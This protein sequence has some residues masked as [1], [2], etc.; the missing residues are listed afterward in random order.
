MR[1]PECKKL[2]K[3]VEDGSV[4]QISLDQ[5]VELLKFANKRYCDGK[6]V[7]TDDMFDLIK[8]H[9]ENKDPQNPF[10]ATVGA[11]VGVCDRR[12]T[13]LPYFMGSMN[14]IKSDGK[15]LAKFITNYSGSYIITDKLDGNSALL[16]YNPDGKVKMF[17]RGDGEEGQ[18]ISEIIP[19]IQ[20]VPKKLK[21]VKSEF[22][23][24]GELII[25]KAD[26]ESM[27]SGRANAR[28]MVAGLI[29]A[30]KL[31][32]KYLPTVHFVAYSQVFPTMQTPVTQLANLKKHGFE[33]V[34]NTKLEQADL[35]F[36]R[37]SEILVSRKQTSPYEVDGIVIAHN[38]AHPLVTKKERNPV[39]SFA[40]K[41]AIMEDSA[42]VIV[43]GVEWNI[44]SHGYLKP[45]VLFDPVTLK[46]VSI[47]RATG[48]HGQFIQSNRIGVGAR[49]LLTRS[50][51]V[52]PHI[53]K[54][55]APAEKT[56]MP[57]QPYEWTQGGKDIKIVITDQGNAEFDAKQVE[58]FFTTLKVKGFGPGYIKKVIDAGFD[59][60]G[61]ILQMTTEQFKTVPG[62]DKKA[63][64]FHDTIKATVKSANCVTIM[65]A[66][67]M[68]GRGM[69]E[70]KMQKI[71]ETVPK[72][73]DGN[74]LPTIAEMEAAGI[75]DA[76]TIQ[77]FLQGLPKFKAFMRENGIKACDVTVAAAKPVAEPTGSALDNQ[78]VLM[79]GF[80]NDDLAKQVVANGGRVVAAFSKKV[81]ILVAKETDKDTGKM[82]EA[83]AAGIRIMSVDQFVKEYKL[84]K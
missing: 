52:I 24:R 41:N 30:K 23:V 57:T 68:F 53:V 83:R 9:L 50:G 26:F 62:I 3:Q 22:T 4:D 71:M 29:N 73:F 21:G 31:D 10:L 66:T 82:K 39:H 14:K 81:T 64:E 8:E 13:K 67:N 78:V 45:T 59:T 38:H 34:Y 15:E 35:T 51:D 54:V 80:R 65:K 56:L 6:P 55:L 84:T 25:S 11:Q 2:I 44:S 20:G 27:Q 47:Q 79:T 17:T 42:E 12:K 70:T 63:Q 5:V 49:V 40:F 60:V 1:L 19:H 58:H 28:N 61:K 32:L 43:T 77:M 72:L 48:F 7:M 18:E 33:V 36:Q 75:K 46:G 69:G 76:D 16:Q 74:Y 37:L